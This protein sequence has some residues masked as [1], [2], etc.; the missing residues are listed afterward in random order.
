MSKMKHSFMT[1]KMVVSLMLYDSYGIFCLQFKSA[2]IGLVLVQK[3]L[4]GESEIAYS[5]EECLKGAF[6]S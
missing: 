2:A 4:T 3:K 1:S 5:S 6:M